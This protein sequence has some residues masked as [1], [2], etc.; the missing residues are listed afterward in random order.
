MTDIERQI[1]SVGL[2]EKACGDVE[3][4][5]RPFSSIFAES[6]IMGYG[7]THRQTHRQTN[8]WTYPLIE[9]RGRIKKMIMC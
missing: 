4:Q 1:K 2:K 9:M 5:I 3:S 6:N 7:C 8:K